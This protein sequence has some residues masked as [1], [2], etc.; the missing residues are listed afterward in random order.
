MGGCVAS[1]SVPVGD[2]SWVTEPACNPASLVVGFGIFVC[3]HSCPGA[4]FLLSS[5]FN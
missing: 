1:G 3:Y 5:F 2:R 4:A